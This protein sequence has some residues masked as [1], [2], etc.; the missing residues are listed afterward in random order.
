MTETISGK[1]TRGRKLRSV[2]CFYLIISCIISASNEHPGGPVVRTPCFHCNGHRGHGSIPGWGSKI[3]QAMWLSQKTQKQANKT[4]GWSQ[5]RSGVRQGR[6]PGTLPHFQPAYLLISAPLPVGRGFLPWSPMQKTK[7]YFPSLLPLYCHHPL[8]FLA[9]KSRFP[10][11]LCSLA[12]W[13]LS[14]PTG[15][16]LGRKEQTHMHGRGL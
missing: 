6:S 14:Q 3:Q 16:T 10:Q 13:Q 5:L 11:R 9:C 7:V 12:F 1:S 4:P 2:D 8:L 15:S